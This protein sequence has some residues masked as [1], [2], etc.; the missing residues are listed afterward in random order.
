MIHKTAR[1]TIRS[2][3]KTCDKTCDFLIDWFGGRYTC[4][5]FH[6]MLETRKG[7]PRTCEACKNMARAQKNT[8]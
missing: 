2:N 3:N 1:G 4:L 8:T 5:A 6:V 7:K